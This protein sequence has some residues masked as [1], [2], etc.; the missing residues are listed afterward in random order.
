MQTAL[1]QGP[2]S[3]LGTYRGSVATQTQRGSSGSRDHSYRRF[4][5]TREAGR[6]L[7]N[8]TLTDGKQA[9]TCY[10]CRS[11]AV[12]GA[13][14]VRVMRADD[15]S[16][17]HVSGLL[18][19]GM[20]WTCPV[21]GARIAEERR[22]ELS[23]ALETWTQKAGGR[24][25]LVSFTTPHTAD[26]AIADTLERFTNAIKWFRQSP[27]YKA[28][29]GPK[30]S[31]GRIGSVKSMETTWGANGFH[32]HTHELIFCRTAYAFGEGDP[33]HNDSLHSTVIDRLKSK[34][35][36]CLLRAGLGD[37]Q[38]MN[39]MLTY[40][41]DFRGGEK[42]AEYVTKYGKEEAWGLS[43]ELTRGPVKIGTR[44]EVE[45]VKHY[46]PF[47]LLA[48]SEKS[49]LL[50]LNGQD[51]E[52]A[53]LFRQY[54]AAFKGRRQ[55][56]WSP[57]LEKKLAEYGYSRKD[58]EDADIVADD[59]GTE[60]VMSLVGLLDAVK[61][62]V[63]VSRDAIGLFH[64]FVAEHCV[65]PET[66]QQDIDDFIESIRGNPSK[67]S[68]AVFFRRGG[69]SPEDRILRIDERTRGIHRGSVQGSGGGRYGD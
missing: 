67:G 57:L 9:P 5:L 45:G 35:V 60:A 15:G 31:A 22:E 63:L 17:A 1:P 10:C 32:P 33:D 56:V 2:S 61:L 18:R 34:W 23:T 29:L 54:A 30:G 37:R 47:E 38:K 52:P 14:V 19:C 65:D 43:S 39:D 62:A 26:M 21:C 27:A 3:I 59:A 13:D 20:P 11:F 53:D 49:M 69:K 48:L 25:Y 50:M 8:S 41:L 55:L 42:A 66:G 40:G 36:D 4:D 64:R 58:R 12:P 46:T 6:V 44:I 68:G 16:R 7:Y 24:C 28:I 51:V